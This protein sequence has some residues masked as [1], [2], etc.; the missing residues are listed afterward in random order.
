MSIETGKL[1][2][3]DKVLVRPRL[4]IKITLPEGPAKPD[5]QAEV[6]S[7]RTWTLATIVEVSGADAAEAVTEDGA[8]IKIDRETQWRWP[9]N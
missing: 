6:T 5:S 7:G 3:G 2:V 8:V 1:E 4:L 9:N